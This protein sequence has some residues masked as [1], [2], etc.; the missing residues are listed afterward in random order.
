MEVLLDTYALIFFLQ[1]SPRMKESLYELIEAEE[2]APCVSLA[3]L[4]EIS[5]KHSHG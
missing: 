1:D 3:S 5:L 4:W 2:H